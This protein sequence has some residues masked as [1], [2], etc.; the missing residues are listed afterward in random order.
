MVGSRAR[1]TAAEIPDQRGRS[2]VVTG[3]NSGLGFETARMLAERGAHVVLACRNPERATAA[4]EAIR[5][6]AP[7]AE[8]SSV[9][10]DLAD[11]GS[12]RAAAEELRERLAR[13]DLLINNAGAAFGELSLVEGVDRTFATN[14]LGPFAFTGLLLDRV[15]AAPAGR[16]V[17]VSSNVS[18]MDELD[19]DDL[20]YARRGYGRWKA[21][22]QS[23]LAN[24]VFAL[25][26]QR[27]LT[28]A[29]AKT[30]VTAAHPGGANTDFGVNT[31]GFVGFM[32]SKTMRR[33]TAPLAI[34]AERGALNTL[35]AAVDPEVRGGEFFCPDRLRNM[36]GY[37]AARD[38]GPVASDPATGARLW[39]ICTRLSGVEYAFPA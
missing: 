39:E 30:L 32:G 18:G 31:G 11:A 16:I 33:F 4:A 15:L 27:R 25:E 14:Q 6:T 13:I 26:L 17:M 35:R 3:A 12:I 28:A 8:L 5:L 19:L 1:W 22:A 7:D 36:R 20:D 37:P 23:K 2:V 34:S 10:L 38:P 9:R 24:L 29:D 21:Y